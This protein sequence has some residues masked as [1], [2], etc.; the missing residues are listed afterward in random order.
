[1]IFLA[2]LLDA[3][4]DWA[5]SLCCAS[6]YSD[7]PPRKAVRRSTKSPKMMLGIFYTPTISSFCCSERTFV[8]ATLSN[9]FM[10]LPVLFLLASSA[11]LGIVSGCGGGGGSAPGGGAGTFAV[12]P[13]GGTFT[14]GRARVIVPPGALSSNTVLR[15]TTTGLLA[16]DRRTISATRYNVDFSGAALSAP[17]TLE[18]SYLD[19]E[20][21]DLREPLFEI[22]KVTTNRWM[23]QSGSTADTGTNKV[24]LDITAAG[25][26][27]VMGRR[28]ATASPKVLY[29]HNDGKLRLLNADG[30]GTSVLLYTPDASDIGGGATASVSAATFAP[31]Q[32]TIFF[33][34]EITTLGGRVSDVWR[35]QDDGTGLTRIRINGDAPTSLDANATGTGLIWASVDPTGVAGSFV[36]SF[37]IPSNTAYSHGSGTNGAYG[38]FTDN[39]KAFRRFDRVVNENGVNVNRSFY[40]LSNLDASGAENL[41]TPD[42]AT[43]TVELVRDSF[44]SPSGLYFVIGDVNT[45]PT[46]AWRNIGT[47][48]TLNISGVAGPLTA[49]AA[50]WDETTAYLAS[51]DSP[52]TLYRYNVDTNVASVVTNNIPNVNK[53]FDLR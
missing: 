48:A 46:I 47:G 36:T 52:S 44:V 17:V 5:H 33:V 43:R 40:S 51:G 1:M 24:E 21:G 31:N 12:G 26:F 8:R 10:K 6:E 25:Q 20:V 41:T 13:S 50:S 14:F 49:A 37:D 19:G 18:L 38:G 39:G 11:V 28:T 53:I 32:S 9:E 23:P 35:V 2:A 42:L 16:S 22:G 29:R 15:L 30:T 4:R 27:C 34:R 3:F 7:A 45:G